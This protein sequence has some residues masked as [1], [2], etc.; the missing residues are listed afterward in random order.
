MLQSEKA[1]F[2]SSSSEASFFFFF[3]LVYL[4]STCSQ[5]HTYS[6]TRGN[7]VMDTCKNDQFSLYC[8]QMKR[9][10][11]CTSP[12]TCATAWQ[13]PGWGLHAGGRQV[14]EPV[15]S[16]QALCQVYRHRAWRC[17]RHPQKLSSTMSYIWD[18]EHYWLSEI[19]RLYLIRNMKRIA[20]YMW[21]FSVIL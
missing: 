19:V 13:N 10:G 3:S 17:Q 11:V 5:L 20:S 8:I 1:S 7:D 12:E 2:L 14:Q 15:C 9:F 4:H 16:Q 18:L 21:A 6:T